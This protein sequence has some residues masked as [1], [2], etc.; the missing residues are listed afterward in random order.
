MKYS[1][2]IL[3]EQSDVIE[4]EKSSYIKNPSLFIDEID[5]EELFEKVHIDSCIWNLN[6]AKLIKWNIILNWDIN[7]F[8]SLNKNSSKKEN[9]I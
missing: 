6:C 3:Q 7:W 4:K 8:L 9:Y 2:S 5:N 1:K